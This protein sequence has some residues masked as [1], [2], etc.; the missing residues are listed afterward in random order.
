[1][2][3][4]ICLSAIRVGELIIYRTDLGRKELDD[5]IFNK[6]SQ[7]VCNQTIR[8]NIFF[9]GKNIILQEWDKYKV[10]ALDDSFSDVDFRKVGEYGAENYGTLL[11]KNCVGIA[12]FKKIRLV[13]ESPKISS[14]EM[15][16]LID[17]EI[18]RAHV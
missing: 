7:L 10:R 11:F 4:R 15:D 2:D 1:M 3:T 9:D 12:S 8:G 6:E 14:E 17:V 13:I 5:F 16:N 18:G